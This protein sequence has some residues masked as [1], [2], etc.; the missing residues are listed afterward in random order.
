MSN[1]GPVR[2]GTSPLLHAALLVGGWLATL[3]LLGL[4][5]VAPRIPYLRLLPFVGTV[6]AGTAVLVVLL[7]PTRLVFGRLFGLL[8]LGVVLV[9]V[10]A[11]AGLM[12]SDTVARSEGLRWYTA[13]PAVEIPEEPPGVVAP[14]PATR[15]IP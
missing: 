11:F 1:G 15:Q 5:V 8:A 12:A 7:V 2:N 3:G 14:A 9:I 10:G 6:A 4:L 13:P